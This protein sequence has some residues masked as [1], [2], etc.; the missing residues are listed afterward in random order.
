MTDR[1]YSTS[2]EVVRAAIGD[3]DGLNIL[4]I[5]CGIGEEC[6]T[7]VAHGAS[8]TGIDPNPKVIEQAKDKGGGAD[9]I[10]GTTQ[11][12]DFETGSFDLI[13]FGYSLHH[14]P[15]MTGA[16]ED[17]IRL[18]KP[19]GRIIILEPQADDPLYPV[20]RWLDDEK[21]VYQLAQQAIDKT[22]ASGRV[23]RLQTSLFA[24]KYAY[25]STKEIV[26]HMLQVDDNR[27]VSED[28]I[29]KVDE[30]YKKA[31]RHGEDGPYIDHWYRMDLL[32]SEPGK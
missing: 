12:T 25:K 15:D 26:E 4:D 29:K 23:K 16:L 8:A 18:V 20:I 28:T 30:A 6:R 22:V 19:G 21:E 5:G 27:K 2:I 1:P 14:I 31:V 7:F 9:Y 13:Y 10:T 3:L 11:S 32:L 24:T 17:A